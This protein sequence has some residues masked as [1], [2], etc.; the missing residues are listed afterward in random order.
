MN[1][2]C[3]MRHFGGAT[4]LLA[5][6]ALGGLAGCG[7]NEPRRSDTRHGV[8]EAFDDAGITAGVKAAILRDP[9]LKVSDINVETSQ[10]VVQLSGFVGSADSVAAAATVARTVR[11]VKSVR[12]DLRLK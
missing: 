6:L 12:N 2:H 11:G 9:E 5:L 4:A 8:A 7:S 1:G 3:D 10:G